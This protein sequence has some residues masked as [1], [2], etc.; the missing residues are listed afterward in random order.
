MSIIV[1][2]KINFLKIANQLN[3]QGFSVLES[4]MTEKLC[5]QYLKIINSNLNKIKN[6]KKFHGKDSS[7][8]YNLTNINFNFFKLIF[9]K[10]INKICK[11]YFQYGAYKGD[12]N[13]YQFDH[14][15]SRILNNPCKAQR[16]HI[17]SR[18]CGVNPPTSLHFF[19]Y[20]SDIDEDSGPTQIVP[21]SHKIKRYPKKSDEKNAIKILG[22]K[23]TII[24]TNSSAWHGSSLKKNNNQRAIITL[25]FTRWFFRQQFAIPFSLPKKFVNKF[26]IKEKMLLGFYNYPSINEVD[27]LT[28]RGTLKNYILK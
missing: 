7:V 24:V 11:D 10:K 12:K 14:M 26:T 1:N 23:G 25:V 5:D 8:L 9:D 28:S 6:E 27:R 20:L 21:S 2:S 3:A 17:D 16:L 15:H 4:K 13:I 18:I 22:K 19:I